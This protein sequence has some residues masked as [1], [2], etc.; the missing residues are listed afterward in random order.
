MTITTD[1]RHTT[2][3]TTSEKGYFNGRIGHEV[4]IR[5]DFCNSTIEIASCGNT[6]DE[7]LSGVVFSLEA[8]YNAQVDLPGFV[9]QDI[10]GNIKLGYDINKCINTTLGLQKF[11]EYYYLF[12]LKNTIPALER[13]SFIAEHITS[14]LCDSFQFIKG[15]LGVFHRSK[16]N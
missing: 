15:R 1:H 8:R 3:C 12:G 5:N 11:I 7:T 6:G 13:T 9:G 16:C 2:T 14:L 10:A 4:K